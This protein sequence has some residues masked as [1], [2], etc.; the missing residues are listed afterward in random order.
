MINLL[1]FTN[2]LNYI[3]INISA[4]S[5]H[6]FFWATK[7]MFFKVQEMGENFK[8]F[9]KKQLKLVETIELDLT[10]MYLLISNKIY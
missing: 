9:R 5:E 10:F 4:Q 6:L 2:I 3:E 7:K 8:A 1:L